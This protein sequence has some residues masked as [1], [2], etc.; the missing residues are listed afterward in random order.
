M[1]T[2]IAIII[3]SND[4]DDDE[5]VDTDDSAMISPQGR[6]FCL[7]TILAETARGDGSTPRSVL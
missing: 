1:P 6:Q 7:L 3:H 4:L 5:P 2:N